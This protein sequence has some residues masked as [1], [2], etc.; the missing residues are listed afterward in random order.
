MDLTLQNDVTQRS[1]KVVQQVASS[2][3]QSIVLRPPKVSDGFA[4]TTLIQNSPP[5]D[6]NSAYCNLLQATHFADTCIVAEQDGQIVGWISAYRPPK[7]LSRIFVWQVA[8]SLEVRG[9]GLAKKMLNSLLCRESVKDANYLIT[10]ITKDNQQSWALF[11]SFASAR[12][13]TM[14]KTPHFEK[15]PH[16]LGAHETEWLVEIGPFESK[17]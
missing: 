8:V 15:D 1:G 7:D 12:N 14:V 16:F 9:Q 13:L 3:N 6:V 2:I 4:I 5:L 10:T 17:T 11:E